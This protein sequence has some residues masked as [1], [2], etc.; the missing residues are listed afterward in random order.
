[1]TTG[2]LLASRL[3]ILSRASRTSPS[4]TAIY[5]IAIP[6]LNRSNLLLRRQ[7]NMGRKITGLDGFPASPMLRD[8]VG[9]TLT[10]ILQSKRTAKTQFGER[11][12]YQVK[13][14]DADC[15][16]TKDG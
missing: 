12:V 10:G 2:I 4:T 3:R 9:A 14:I 15:E 1:M 16:F 6:S 8:K 5:Q 7:N 13:L 11:P